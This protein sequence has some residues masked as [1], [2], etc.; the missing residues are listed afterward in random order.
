MEK[1][2]EF[3][4]RKSILKERPVQKSLIFANCGPERKK[5]TNGEQSTNKSTTAEIPT[6]KRNPTVSDKPTR[7]EKSTRSTESDRFDIP[8]RSTKIEFGEVLCLKKKNNFEN[9]LHVE[10]FERFVVAEKDENF[11]SELSLCL[12]DLGANATISRCHVVE[13][14]CE[15]GRMRSEHE[16]GMSAQGAGA[17]SA[18]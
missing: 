14:K 8:E 15:N 9:N 3:L 13:Q 4:Q 5:S 11:D 6:K 16:A 10:K 1:I 12:T 18:H 7:P 2:G 17:E